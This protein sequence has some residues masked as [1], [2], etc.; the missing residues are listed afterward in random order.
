M[1]S[2]IPAIVVGVIAPIIAMILRSEKRATRV[3]LLKTKYEQ[4]IAILSDLICNTTELCIAFADYQEVPQEH[5]TKL[6]R[7]SII[8]FCKAR[9]LLPSEIY[10]QFKLFFDEASAFL[11]TVKRYKAV[12]VD[13]AVCFDGLKR[14]VARNDAGVMACKVYIETFVAK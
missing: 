4:V 13:D 10:G 3:G 14:V 9:L 5:L 8:G 1:M 7:A 2:A 11:N 6:H 12:Q